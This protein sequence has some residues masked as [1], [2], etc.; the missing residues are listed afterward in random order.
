MMSMTRLF[1]YHIII[2][3]YVSTHIYIYYT[4]MFI[5]ERYIYYN[6]WRNDIN[7]LYYM[8]YTISGL[9]S[10]GACYTYTVPRGEGAV[11]AT[12]DS[13]NSLRLPSTPHWPLAWSLCRQRQGPIF[14][15]AF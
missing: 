9:P 3:I 14:T 13:G 1:V 12:M 7:I 4:C 8:H 2:Y 11:I 10:S 6:A 5:Y 15:V